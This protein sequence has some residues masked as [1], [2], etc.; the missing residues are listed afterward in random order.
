MAEQRGTCWI[1]GA[2]N[3]PVKEVK[4]IVGT[5]TIGTATLKSK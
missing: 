1:T 4:T 3:V 5:K 2:K